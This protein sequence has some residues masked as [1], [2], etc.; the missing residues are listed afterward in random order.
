MRE[1]P[2]VSNESIEASIQASY[3]IVVTSLTFLPLGHDSSAWVYRA[4]AVGG[5]A[6]FLKLRRGAVCEP[7][8]VVPRHLRDRGV[9][10]VVAPLPTATGALWADLG[11]FVLILYPF[12]EARAGM[13]AGLTEDQWV[14]FG[15]AV[16]ELHTTPLTP[17]LRRLVGRETFAP[18][19][20]GATKSWEAASDLDERITAGSFAEP[21]ERELAA[22]WRARSP[23]IRGLI[24]RAEDLARRLRRAAPPPA[25][26]HADLHTGN[27]LVAVDDRLWIVDWDETVLAPK[28]RDLMF[29][30]GGG[31][32][33]DLVGRR[34]EELFF[35]GYGETAMDPLALAYYRHAWAVQDISD[36]GEQVFLR[37]ELGTASK[38]AA[39]EL[40]ESLFDPGSIVALAHESAPAGG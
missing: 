20:G 4:E 37:P 38:R 34:E 32:S 14:A 18:K 24:A 31:I 1:P 22:F 30:A 26:C 17:E 15:K 29:V 7:G 25:L 27:V 10:H 36:F 28:E 12:I 16:K 2:E 5:A 6:Y 33:R 13:D 11:E 40:F 8:L 21:T 23:E 35:R 19:W 3:D 39:A 9:A